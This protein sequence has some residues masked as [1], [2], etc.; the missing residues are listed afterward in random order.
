MA[1]VTKECKEVDKLKLEKEMEGKRKCEKITMEANVKK[2][3][4]TE[5][6]LGKGIKIC[7]T[8]LEVQPFGGNYKNDKRL[9]R[10]KWLCF[11]GWDTE[12]ESHLLS[13]SARC[14]ATWWAWWRT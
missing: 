2:K 11:C 12:E 5:R 14:T 4:L 6:I 7:I 10:T 8:W 9:E 13:G 3:Y 1:L